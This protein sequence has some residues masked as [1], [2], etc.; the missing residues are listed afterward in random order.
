MS[1][2]SSETTDAAAGDA[3][4]AL[5]FA[6]GMHQLM[7]G[8]LSA[9]E[10]GQL[11]EA[12]YPG[13][14]VPHP[15]A[16]QLEERTG[17]N[18]SF[19]RGALS[20]MEEQGVLVREGGD[21]ALAE[22]AIDIPY[23]A[24]ALADL[25]RRTASLEKG[26]LE[27]LEAAAVLAVAAGSP[28]EGP[29]Q[30][31]DAPSDSAF[32]PAAPVPADTFEA[33]AG[34]PKDAFD[35]AL[36]PLSAAGRARRGG[37]LVPV[38]GGY[39]FDLPL[40]ATLVYLRIPAARKA[41]LHAL[42]AQQLEPS[43]KAGAGPALAA[44]LGTHFLEAGLPAEAL[45][46]ALEAGT[47]LQQRHCHDQALAW[48][49]RARAIL[50][51]QA[52]GLDE[53][54]REPLHRRLAE[55]E[56]W[57]GECLHEVGRQ[58]E[59]LVHLE[60]ARSLAAG[61]VREDLQA[62]S[63][64]YMSRAFMDRGDVLQAQRK[65]KDAEKLAKRAGL[66]AERGL[67]LSAQALPLS[68]SG[69]VE[70]A[71]E[72]WEEAA[73]LL[74]ELGHG[75]DAAEALFRLGN[76]KLRLDHYDEAQSCYERAA[77]LIQDANPRL[78][79]RI[80]NARGAVLLLTGKPAEALPMF[81][82]AAA[83][84]RRL[85][86]RQEEASS[87]HNIAHCHHAIGN[88]E[89]ASRIYSQVIVLRRELG[90]SADR[91]GSQRNH[92]EVLLDLG[93]I[94]EA[95]SEATEALATKRQLEDLGYVPHCLNLVGDIELTLGRAQKAREAFGE[96]VRDFPAV[97]QEEFKAVSGLAQAEWLAGSAEGA[98]KR[99]EELL[100]RMAICQ[101][102]YAELVARER[103]VGYFA[104][105]GASPE[106]LRDMATPSASIAAEDSHPMT[107]MLEARIR[108]VP[109][110]RAGLVEKA[111]AHLNEALEIGRTLGTVEWNWRTQRDL[112]LLEAG[113]SPARA[114]GLRAAAAILHEQAARLRR[115]E[116]KTA[117]LAHR[118]RAELLKIAPAPID[119]GEATTLAG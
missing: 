110:A 1:A 4:E 74:E 83:I 44:A 115:E 55:V 45:P 47:L 59:A 39:R 93:K 51:R 105:R 48:F 72:R 75:V 41:A 27:I 21:W 40:T 35:G 87:L 11:A 12:L 67:A 29:E 101:D 71:E 102:S 98:D 114:A 94:E 79:A 13:L 113:D 77:R 82:Q 99:F 116:L 109:A 31:T 85:G 28:P 64:I 63:L 76:Q 16:L 66:E 91:A 84:R 18:P 32:P 6:E 10:L 17:G 5:R 106:R 20:Q 60:S 95:L 49:E 90:A 42:A 34:M 15:V 96:I 100:S 3:L 8:G 56:L 26:S 70:D 97:I 19:A 107:R 112:A 61:A 81:E 103:L 78:Q 57:L 36:A 69:D 33:I 22:G 30:A 68:R 25:D 88:L 119:P 58:A 86:A 104:A 62:R 92:A 50:E 111:R 24:R 80:L 37:L 108:S 65:A 9:G 46:Y 23:P 54:A 118:E 73:E 52:E 2:R 38:P 14:V 89:A 53:S 43:A 7:L 117:Y